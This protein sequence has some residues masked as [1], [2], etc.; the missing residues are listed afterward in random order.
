MPARSPRRRRPP[1]I[2]RASGSPFRPLAE[3]RGADPQ[4]RGAE[5]DGGG[6]IRAHAHRQEPEAV[7]LGDLGGERKMR[8]R[9]L[10]H[11]R[12]AHEA[13]NRETVSLAAGGEKCIG[14]LRQYARLLRFRPGIDLDEEERR[15]LLP[16]D[17]L[18]QGLA[19]AGTID[20]MD[21]VEER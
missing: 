19:Q 16:R 1:A 11:G 5:L 14:L 8:A 13:G 9:S 20:R 4:M 18:R 10:V 21:G 15:A 12:K 2:R 3:Y 7:A 6:K 17:F